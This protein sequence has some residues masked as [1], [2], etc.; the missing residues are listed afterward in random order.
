MTLLPERI[1]VDYLFNPDFG[2]VVKVFDIIGVEHDES[3][4]CCKTLNRKDLDGTGLW[5]QDDLLLYITSE[6]QAQVRFILED[7]VGDGFIGTIQSGPGQGKS[8]T[9]YYASLV[10]CSSMGWK[11]LW[12]RIGESGRPPIIFTLDGKRRII[13]ELTEDEISTLTPIDGEKILVIIDF[14]GPPFHSLYWDE[15]FTHWAKMNP[16]ERRYFCIRGRWGDFVIERDIYKNHN[17]FAVHIR[18]SW[19]Y[20]ELQQAYEVDEFYNRWKSFL[21][22]P[23]ESLQ[24]RFE[25]KFAIVGP[26]PEYM[27]YT[28]TMKVMQTYTGLLEEL[29]TGDRSLVNNRP[30]YLL[31]WYK[32]WVFRW[33]RDQCSNSSNSENVSFIRKEYP[34]L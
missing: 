25:A 24:K 10:A 5:N 21:D 8:V 9:S 18:D 2:T 26:R 19:G 28:G 6:F 20:G 12:I 1:S 33:V 11:V 13:H 32:G 23:G 17:G 3:E 27:F 22:L 4:N 30:L 16:K 7:V 34:R 14:D 29:L 31:L 15:K